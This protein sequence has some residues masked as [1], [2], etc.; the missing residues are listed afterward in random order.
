[1]SQEDASPSKSLA[2]EPVVSDLPGVTAATDSIVSPQCLHC[3]RVGV[4]T[5]VG[6]IECIRSQSE[7]GCHACGSCSCY[8]ASPTCP[9]SNRARESHD[10]AQATGSP[11]QDIFRRSI[12]RV[13]RRSNCTEVSIDGLRFE[14]GRASSVRNNC[15][16]DALRQAIHEHI[17]CV[18]DNEWVRS[19]LIQRFSQIGENRVTP[20]SF[21]DFRVHW[22]ST[23]DFI[24]ESAGRNG[25]D[26]LGRIR[27]ESFR[28]VCVEERTSVVGDADGE[29]NLELH[30]LNE[31]QLHYVPLLRRPTA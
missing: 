7:L 9:F 5:R 27:A 21:L 4:E 12:V 11:A 15:L 29:G 1:M 26:A 22:R 14:K 19:K 13:H 3:D 2:T 6:S 16:I 20:L 18:V 31:S 17:P 28:A 8:S 24:G 23:V 25:Q 10:D 30:L